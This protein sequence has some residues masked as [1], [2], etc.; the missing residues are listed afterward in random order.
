MS[1]NT[2]PA[3][4]EQSLR[5]SDIPTLV[6]VLRARRNQK[7]DVVMPTNNLRMRGGNLEIAGL[8]DIEVPAVPASMN[9]N[10]VTPEVPGFTFNPSGLYSP[11]HVV[12]QHLASL[13]E[14]PVRYLRK[15]RSQDVELLDTTINR[16]ADRY[17]GSNLVRLIWG[18]MAGRDDLTGIVRAILSDRYAIID[19][20][21]TVM[22]IL[23]GLK[24]AGLDGSNIKGIDLSDQRLYLNIEV[25]EIAVHG[26]SLVKGYRSPFTGQT[27]EELPM[28]HAGLKF[29]NS[30]IGRGAF[31]IMPYAMFE[32]C[33][34]GATID[35]FKMRKVHLGKQLDQ[36]EI[37]WSQATLNA[38]NEL[39]RNQVR[40][41]VGQFL[42]TDFLD[43][44]VTGW[45]AE[46][47][48]EIAKPV[49]VLQVV[50]K[51]LSYTEVEQDLIL[52]DF[53]KG[54]Q[55][56]AF[57]IGHAVTAA[58]QRIED[59]DRANELQESHL[60]AVRIAAREA[61]SA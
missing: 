14:I 23:S 44:V 5:N 49:D 59:P 53:I 20:L 25:P 7:V 12:D 15:L 30:E 13:F 46:A 48:V 33:S 42:T 24:E 51:E 38:A 32:V 19:H 40:D 9:E 16:H 57:A 1:V 37:K 54:G 60:A 31:E 58:A 29:T 28:V 6:S 50:S 34:N 39:V 47:G 35:A 41:A 43:K 3:V 56:N 21:D 27:G 11:T 8:D 22:S 55:T 61:V 10:G 2:L 52:S 26:R 45:E 17:E 18:S 4:P 36:G